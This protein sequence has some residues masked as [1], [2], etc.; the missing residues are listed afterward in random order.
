M[1]VAG[2]CRT[3]NTKHGLTRSAPPGIP[4]GSRLARLV[5]P[6]AG[7]R[8]GRWRA[9][10]LTAVEPCAGPSTDTI[11]CVSW[12]QLKASV[13]GPA[14]GTT[15]FWRNARQRFDASGPWAT[16]GSPTAQ[17]EQGNA[18]C[19]DRAPF[20]SV[21]AL[22]A[23]KGSPAGS[24]LTERASKRYPMGSE[25]EVPSIGH[26]PGDESKPIMASRPADSSQDV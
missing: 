2:A 18:P 22:D 6:R 1:A 8:P 25:L 21:A 26:P 17:T 12:R 24:L 13:D 14:R 19:M 3:K 10:R 23:A 15:A 4:N 16:D 5:E 9:L 20:A 7:R 11:Y